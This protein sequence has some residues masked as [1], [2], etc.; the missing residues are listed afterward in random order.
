MLFGPLA[1]PAFDG[2]NDLVNDTTPTSHLDGRANEYCKETPSASGTFW[3]EWQ[4]YVQS[5]VSGS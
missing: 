1:L 4:E 5:T 2:D 3:L